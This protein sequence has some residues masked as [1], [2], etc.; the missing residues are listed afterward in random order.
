MRKAR[1]AKELGLKP[2]A[3]ELTHYRLFFVGLEDYTSSEEE[4]QL[5]KKYK[6]DYGEKGELLVH[7]SSDENSN[8]SFEGDIHNV[9]DI[10]Q[11]VDEPSLSQILIN[12]GQS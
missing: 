10:I 3:A 2:D 12:Q 9:N 11:S 4:R 8:D 7:S 1:I 6:K 5:I